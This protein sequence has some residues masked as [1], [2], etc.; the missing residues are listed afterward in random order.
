MDQSK[1]MDAYMT[2][3]HHNYDAQ[4]RKWDKDAQ[5][6][7]EESGQGLWPAVAMALAAK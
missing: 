7:M 1:F 4:K 6:Q 2:L 3:V 5:K